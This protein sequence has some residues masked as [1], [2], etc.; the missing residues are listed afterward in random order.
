ML[1]PSSV[2]VVID[3]QNDF[4]A[5][6]A[7]FAVDEKAQIFLRDTLETFVPTFRSAGGHI[8][9]IK[10]HYA[11]ATKEWKEKVNAETSVDSDTSTPS[12]RLD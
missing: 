8:I 12:V 11:I 6:S 7:S 5:P 1:Q 3:L 4:L 2:L 9:W 10:S